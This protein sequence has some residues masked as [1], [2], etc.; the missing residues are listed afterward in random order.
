MLVDSLCTGGGGTGMV[1]AASVG[2]AIVG[3]GILLDL[4]IGGV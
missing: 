3:K 1:G 2:A 4:P